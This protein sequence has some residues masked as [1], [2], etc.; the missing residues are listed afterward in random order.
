MYLLYYTGVKLINLNTKFCIKDDT[1][2]HIPGAA[3]SNAP[4]MEHLSFTKA[5]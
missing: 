1:T 2:N 3:I 4:D 5:H